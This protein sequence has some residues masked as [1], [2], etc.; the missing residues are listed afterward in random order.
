MT[1]DSFEI[2]FR[3]QV[4]DRTLF[5]VRRRMRVRAFGI[6][7]AALA[8][9]PLAVPVQELSPESDGLLLRSLPLR[10]A[11]PGVHGVSVQPG[12]LRLLCY[13]MQRFPRYYIDMKQSFEDYRRKFSSKTR[14][15]LTRKIRKFAEH[16]GGRLH[17]QAYR[18]ADE[19]DVFMRLARRVSAQTY[20]ERLLDAG[21]PADIGFETDARKLAADNQLR[22]YILFDGDRP[23][24]YLYCPVS[25][26]VIG[27][28][29]LGY[30]P[31]YSQLSVGT[32]L[33]WL[34]L[35]SLFNER[36][37]RYFD[38]TEGESDHK[39]L[40][41]TGHLECAN[42]AFLRPTLAN[43]LLAHGHH[44]FGRTVEAV[45]RRLQE[46]DL[47]TRVKHWLRFGRATP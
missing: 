3:F 21:L 42:V 16:C 17:W 44:A 14:S 22:A 24:S 20:Q 2:P 6:D 28:A 25:D 26:G 41:A 15:T 8:E 40:F 33:Q 5:A 32:V 23:V 34:A 4:S 47:K 29:Y 11:R 27:Y 19:L 1:G 35:E 46:H 31:E 45:G 12:G 10:D 13:V 43:R 18:R 9:H 37:F 7:D 38:F 36:R 39:R 30:D